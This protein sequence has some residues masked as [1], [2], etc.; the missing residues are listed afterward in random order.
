MDDDPHPDPTI[1]HAPLRRW[2]PLSRDE[3]REARAFVHKLVLRPWLTW[4]VVAVL[5]WAYLLQLVLGW[6]LTLF[7]PAADSLYEQLTAE[8]LG[9]QLGVL[10]ADAVARGEL[11]RLLS[12]T[13]LHGSV[14]HLAGNAAVLFVL[15]RLVENVYGRSAWLV[16]YVGAGAAGAGLSV[17]ASGHDSL[18][19][20]GAILGML[21]MAVAFGTREKARIPR[22]LRDFFG[23]DLWFFVLFVALL[24][25]LPFVDWA[26]HLGGFLWGLAVGWF[27]PSRFFDG[28]PVGRRAVIESSLGAAALAALLAVVVIVGGRIVR[29]DE[30]MPD[31]DL[32][33][34]R[35]AFEREDTQAQ[36][37]IAQRLA[38]D[39]ADVLGV[40]LLVSQAYQGAERWDLAVKSA[41]ALEEQWPELVPRLE[42]WNNNL[43]WAIFR[44]SPDDPSAIAEGL[45]RVRADLKQHPDD[46]VVRNTLGLGLYRN[47][48]YDRAETVLADLMKGADDAELANDVFIHVLC[49]LALGR[50]ADAAAEYEAH[51]HLDGGE[52]R[53][54]AEAALRT[55]GLIQS[56]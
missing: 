12:A 51:L 17:V 3:Q 18:G 28:P 24:S 54:E 20:S 22:A 56:R 53:D 33:A 16:G 31:R 23:L 13:L 6:P 10:Q 50:D 39:Y 19:A 15:G 32:R 34:L 35:S 45:R 36:V 43:A 30:G 47:A 52:L 41:R 46:P 4:T 5:V 38:A 21:G 49:L 1:D 14:L 44:A 9:R 48:Q 8:F 29:L 26:G 55:R 42:Y 40:Q 37:E 25:M 11:W 27:W 2:S 7:L